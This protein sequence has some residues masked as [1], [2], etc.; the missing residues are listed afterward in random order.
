M[1]AVAAAGRLDRP[2][3]PHTSCSPRATGRRTSCATWTRE[4]REAIAAEGRK[5]AGSLDEDGARLTVRLTAHRE[6][7]SRLAADL[8][9]EADLVLRRRRWALAP[10]RRRQARTDAAARAD[11]AD[12]H[13]RR[14]AQAHE[15]L[16]ELGNSGRH[17]YPWFERHHDVLAP[18]LAAE[19][20]LDGAQ[21]AA[22]HRLGAPGIASL[23]AACLTTTGRSISVASNGSSRRTAG[24]G[25]GCCSRWQPSCMDASRGISLSE[26][27][28]ELD[29]EDLDRVLDAIAVVK[30][31]RST[32]PGS[33]E[34]LWIRAAEPEP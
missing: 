16:R 32:I 22:Y 3:L 10:R 26:L 1:G 33:P 6:R 12:E 2:L 24:C 31:R 15:R 7:H 34:Y 4:Q 14:A 20:T 19:L 13:R 28:A 18:G 30:R 29:G 5:A 11:R 21:S 25:S 9:H 27:L 23:T 8:Q 17:L